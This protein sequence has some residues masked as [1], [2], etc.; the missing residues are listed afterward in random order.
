MEFMLN[1]CQKT[2]VQTRVRT[3]LTWEAVPC[4]C[5]GGLCLSADVLTF[6]SSVRTLLCCSHC[7]EVNIRNIR[8]FVWTVQSLS[9]SIAVTEG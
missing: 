1:Y 2:A 4:A 5:C 8:S 7:R 6:R 9:L 3:M